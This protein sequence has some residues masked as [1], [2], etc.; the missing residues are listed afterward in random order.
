MSTGGRGVDVSCG[1]VLPVQVLLRRGPAHQHPH[2]R[3]PTRQHHHLR[4][5]KLLILSYRRYMSTLS[6][7]IGSYT[8]IHPFI[9]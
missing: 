9:H 8:S 7:V 6:W 4:T 1:R 3:K 5:G 2:L